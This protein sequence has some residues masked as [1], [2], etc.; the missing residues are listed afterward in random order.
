MI[1]QAGLELGYPSYPE[2]QPLNPLGYVE[3]A[4]TIENGMRMNSAKAFLGKIKD[5]K[6]LFLALKSFV[7]KVIID[8]NTKSA[9]G[10]EVTVGERKLRLI[11]KKEVILSGGSINSPQLLMLSGIGPKR[12]LEDLGIETVQDLPVGENLQDHIC[13]GSFFVRLDL[14]NSE[15][16]SM[17]DEVYKYFTSKTG[18]FARTATM[19]TVSFINTKHDSK[20]PDI[21]N[22]HIF[23]PS[24]NDLILPVVLKSSGFIEEISDSKLEAY[25]SGPIFTIVPILTKPKSRGKILLKSKNPKDKPLIYAGYFTDQNDDDITTMLASIR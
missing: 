2:E 15:P 3:M 8:E 25:K 24:A 17:S 20:Y 1:K 19:S 12:H 13:Y 7:K 10:V 11:A 18:D 21:Q 9:R 16:R 22:H 23:V 5:R 6:N 14:N 4:Y